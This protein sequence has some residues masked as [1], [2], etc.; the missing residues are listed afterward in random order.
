MCINQVTKFISDQFYGI[1][2]EFRVPGGFKKCV[3]TGTALGALYS[4]GALS[5]VFKACVDGMLVCSS[6]EFLPAPGVCSMSEAVPAGLLFGR[7]V[8]IG[9]A[10]GLVVGAACRLAVLAES[11]FIETEAGK[12]YI[13]STPGQ[14][15]SEK[16]FGRI[17]I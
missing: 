9:A 1:N 10:V 17:F 2:G 6:E 12:K 14:W 5:N 8:L 11:R 7:G 15:I 3:P 13:N 16:I 4:V